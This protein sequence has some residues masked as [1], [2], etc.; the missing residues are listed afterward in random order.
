MAWD[1]V[2]FVELATIVGEIF[3]I[4]VSDSDVGEG[5]F[6]TVK[7]LTDFVFSRKTEKASES[8]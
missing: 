1:S 5:H 7:S 2:G 4:Q 3:E 8:V 6:T